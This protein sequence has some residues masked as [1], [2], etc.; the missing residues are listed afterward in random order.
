M[1]GELERHGLQR[2][3]FNAFTSRTDGTSMLNGFMR[4]QTF[5]LI[6]QFLF[7]NEEYLKKFVR[8]TTIKKSLI[9]GYNSFPMLQNF[10]N[11][12]FEV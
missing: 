6:S 7:N 10:I 2:M 12:H 8:A 3:K 5:L 4:Y 1:F 9:S 11:R